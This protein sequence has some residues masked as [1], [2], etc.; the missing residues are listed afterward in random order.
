MAMNFLACDREQTFLVP[1]DPRDWLPEGHLS[2]FVLASVGEMDLG[3]FYSSYRQ[4]GWGRAAFEPSMMVA[5]LM[6]A[7]A[8]VSAPRVGSSVAA[9][10]MSP[11]G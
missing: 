1:A 6:Y 7:Y 4:D 11:T 5:L 8:R 3:A 2:W 10:R 9:W